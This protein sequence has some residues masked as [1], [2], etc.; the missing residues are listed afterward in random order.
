MDNGTTSE[1]PGLLPPYPIPS[2]LWIEIFILLDAKDLYLTSALVCKRWGEFV[3]ADNSTLWRL[4]CTRF[5]LCKDEQGQKVQ[6]TVDWKQH[7]KNWL[8]LGGTW[9]KF[10]NNRAAE[11]RWEMQAVTHIELSKMG[12]YSWS[13]SDNWC[14]EDAG[15]SGWTRQ[16]A[17]GHWKVVVGTTRRRKWLVLVLDGNGEEVT[18][19]NNDFYGNQAVTST[20][21]HWV[22]HLEM[23]LDELKAQY[24]RQPICKK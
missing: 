9:T 4:M 13:Y 18:N 19:H 11:S 20:N 10:V 1:T 15:F 23:P 12:T 5:G 21:E 2:E 24:R 17:T 8:I 6:P 16:K 22:H 3:A 7:L 14:D